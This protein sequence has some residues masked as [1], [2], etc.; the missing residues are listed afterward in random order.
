MVTISSTSVQNGFNIDEFT[1]GTIDGTGVFDTMLK[2]VRLHL[3]QEYE[4]ERIR[5]TDYAN[6]Y[7]NLI[8]AVLDKASDYALSKAKIGL[9]MQ[10]LEAQIQKLATDTVVATKQGGL[11]DAQI[12]TEVAQAEKLNQEIEHKLP[13]EL[14]LLEANIADVRQGTAIKEKEIDVMTANIS[15][16]NKDIASKEFDLIHFKPAQIENMRKQTELSQANID[17]INKDISLKEYELKHLKPSQLAHSE[18]ELQLKTQQLELAKKDI[19]VK[20]HQI[21]LGEKDIAIKEQQL[22]LAR[23]E[24]DTKAPLEAKQIQMQADLYAQKVVTEKAQTDSTVI[25]DNSVI[26][27]NNAVLQEQAISYKND[28]KIKMTNI[29]VD[30]WKIR[31]NDDPDEAP[32]TETNKLNDPTIGRA[33]SQVLQSVGI[34]N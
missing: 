20:T 34:T 23:Y 15:N 13:K 22:A 12:F 30:T 8:S 9:E 14:A 4:A 16:I 6:A 18:K 25:G 24:L 10:L 28:A 17:T 21:K 11:I 29:L 33:V 26:A 7:I 27:R 1:T 32:V 2:T 31:R 19:E 3:H 5:G